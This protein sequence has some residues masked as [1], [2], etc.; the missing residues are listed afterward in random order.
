VRVSLKA[1]TAEDFFKKTDAKPEFFDLPFKAIS[2][3]NLIDCGISFHVAAMSADPRIMKPEERRELIKKLAEIEPELLLNLE[4][5][6]VNPYKN[7]LKRLKYAG[8]ELN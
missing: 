1:G 8:I 5:E 3:E 6:I 2:S 7:T 4:E